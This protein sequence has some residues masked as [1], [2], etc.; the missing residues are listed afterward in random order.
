VFT[1][2]L[3][4]LP[5]HLLQA[6]DP[7][8]VGPRRLPVFQQ[9]Q[10]APGSSGMRG[11]AAAAVCEGLEG[12][13]IGDDSDPFGTADSASSMACF[14]AAN[15]VLESPKQG[16]GDTGS[17]DMLAAAAS[18]PT[19]SAGALSAATGSG[20]AAAGAQAGYRAL[21]GESEAPGRL[22]WEGLWR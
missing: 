12:T 8:K 16:Q 19:R 11:A 4:P 17:F 10:A 21:G 22:G 6:A 7:S 2:P 18:H 3:H 1:H 13:G 15:A 20:E 14:L 9:L 5:P